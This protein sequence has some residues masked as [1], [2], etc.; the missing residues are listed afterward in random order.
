MHFQL[1]TWCEKIVVPALTVK[2]SKH[3]GKQKAGLA[4]LSSK[5]LCAKSLEFQTSFII[6]HQHLKF[7]R[8]AKK[9]T[10]S[11]TGPWKQKLGN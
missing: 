7:L 2:K 11:V 10:V 4:N 3:P 5:K 1:C 6:L 9:R 8:S